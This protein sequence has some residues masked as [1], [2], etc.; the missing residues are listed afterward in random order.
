M[1]LKIV[2]EPSAEGAIQRVCPEGDQGPRR[3]IVRSHGDGHGSGQAAQ[4][5]SPP[6]LERVGWP[7]VGE[8]GVDRDGTIVIE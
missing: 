4:P 8:F 3:H 1:R 5:L 7:V 6:F 2:L